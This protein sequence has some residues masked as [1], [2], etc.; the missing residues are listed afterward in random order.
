MNRQKFITGVTNKI[1]DIENMQITLI[2]KPYKEFIKSV[3]KLCLIFSFLAF[4]SFTPLMV[5]FLL[6]VYVL[7][8]YI[9]WI[10]ISYCAK[11]GYKKIMCV[12]VLAGLYF[13]CYI[14]VVNLRRFIPILF[15]LNIQTVVYYIIVPVGLL[16]LVFIF[17]FFA[18]SWGK[19]F[20]DVFKG[21]LMVRDYKNRRNKRR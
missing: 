17:F 20:L 8:A 6:P 1:L 11:F 2:N 19:V 15:T 10:F 4:V 7:F 14:A 16:L 21:F 13:L 5:L 3:I 18:Y 9:N 12:L